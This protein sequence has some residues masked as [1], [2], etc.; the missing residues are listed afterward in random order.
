MSSI[1]NDFPNPSLFSQLHFRLAYTLLPAIRNLIKGAINNNEIN[2]VSIAC[3]TALD[4]STFELIARS[5]GLTFNYFGCDINKK[6]LL[7][8][9]RVIRNKT[10]NINHKYAHC[11]IAKTPP[12]SAIAKADCIL[13]RHPEFLSDHSETPKILIVKMCHILWNI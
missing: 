13:W 5:R 3:G 2:V 6:D 12:K 10:P 9:Y 8:N 1:F 4:A 11:D 7:Y